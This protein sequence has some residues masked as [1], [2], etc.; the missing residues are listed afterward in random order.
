MAGQVL[1][2]GYDDRGRK[3]IMR[4]SWGPGWGDQAT[5]PA[6]QILYIYIYIYTI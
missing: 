6:D 1:C 3:W 2:V 5:A 4:N